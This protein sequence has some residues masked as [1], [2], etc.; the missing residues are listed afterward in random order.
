MV[1][2][3]S[4]KLHNDPAVPRR[5]LFQLRL[6]SKGCILHATSRSTGDA[7][8]MV[9][10]S[11]KNTCICAIVVVSN[12][13][14]IHISEL[15]ELAVQRAQLV[16]LVAVGSEIYSTP[17]ITVNHEGNSAPFYELKV[18]E[19]IPSKPDVAQIFQSNIAST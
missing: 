18:S 14:G 7:R 13:P 9:H 17:E 5:N 4:D 3:L 12:R 2:E 10:S 16:I 8:N 6:A 1:S 11:R 19:P 15:V